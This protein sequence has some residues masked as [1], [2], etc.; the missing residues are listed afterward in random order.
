MRGDPVGPKELISQLVL[1]RLVTSA[2]GS[3]AILGTRGSGGQTRERQSPKAVRKWP[4]VLSHVRG[5]LDG[6][7]AECDQHGQAGGPGPWWRQWFHTGPLRGQ[8]DTTSFGRVR[9]GH[10][11][12]CHFWAGLLC[13]QQGKYFFAVV[14]RAATC[15]RTRWTQS[16][17]RL[18]GGLGFAREKLCARR[19]GQG[20]RQKRTRLRL[21]PNVQPLLPEISSHN[22][23]LG[24]LSSGPWWNAAWSWRSTSPSR[25]GK[26]ST[27]ILLQGSQ[28]PCR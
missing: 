27:D 21:S 28:W 25:R 11:N 26:T 2:Q 20:H 8:A 18:Q 23:W 7:A 3:L 4:S 17:H 13:G 9:S 6:G 16:G 12:V 15:L 5:W 22:A 1:W 19:T 24:R 10:T 14:G